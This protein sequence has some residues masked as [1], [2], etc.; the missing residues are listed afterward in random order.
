MKERSIN[1]ID[2]TAPEHEVEIMIT[3]EISGQK[4][5]VN[6]DGICRLRICGITPDT[7]RIEDKRGS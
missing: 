6:V 1:M 5:W 7:L 4:L 2:I 3:N